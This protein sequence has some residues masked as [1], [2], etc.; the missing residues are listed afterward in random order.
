MAEME[1]TIPNISGDEIHEQNPAVRTITLAEVEVLRLKHKYAKAKD[2][3]EKAK[4]NRVEFSKKIS[5]LDH[6]LLLLNNLTQ[7][8]QQKNEELDCEIDKVVWSQNRAKLTLASQQ[9]LHFGINQTMERHKMQITNRGNEVDSSDEVLTT[10]QMLIEKICSMKKELGEKKKEIEQN[11]L[12]AS[13]IEQENVIMKKRNQAMLV[14]LGRQRQEA[15]LRRQ[16]ILDKLT[17]LRERLKKNVANIGQEKGS[18]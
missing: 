18:N 8:L 4:H 13:K 17:T 1:N 14:R 7:D 3:Y 2:E 10:K 11:E 16:Q 15:E 9:T 5:N 6:S 12:Q